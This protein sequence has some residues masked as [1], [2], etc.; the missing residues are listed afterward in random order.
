MD[1]NGWI[2]LDKPLCDRGNSDYFSGYWGSDLVV[3][4]RGKNLIPSFHI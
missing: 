4:K 3:K 1:K 2:K